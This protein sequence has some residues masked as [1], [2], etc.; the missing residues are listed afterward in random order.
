MI[1]SGMSPSSNLEKGH[2]YRCTVRITDEDKRVF[3]LDNVAITF[4]DRTDTPS[5]DGKFVQTSF[6]LY[7]TDDFWSPKFKFYGLGGKD[8]QSDYDFGRRRKR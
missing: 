2:S 8:T 5:A 3:V 7:F 4:A 1:V 6:R